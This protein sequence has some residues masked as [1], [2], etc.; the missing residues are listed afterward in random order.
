MMP[1]FL[2]LG[3]VHG[4]HD[5]CGWYVHFHNSPY[6]PPHVVFISFREKVSSKKYIF[7]VHKTVLDPE[8][9]QKIIAVNFSRILVGTKI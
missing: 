7:L 4:F 3:S 9:G 2:V 6:L 8:N 1:A 5:F